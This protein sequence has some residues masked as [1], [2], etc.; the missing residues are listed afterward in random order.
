MDDPVDKPAIDYLSCATEII[1]RIQATQLGA[2]K[3]AAKL[4]AECI[5]RDGFVHMFATGHSR[6][7]VEE[8]FPRYGSIV[9]FNPLV[10][11]SL[12][13]HTEVIGSNGHAQATFLE[14]TLG[15][16]E[17]IVEGIPA[18]ET[19]VMLIFSNSGSHTVAVDVAIAARQRRIPVVLVTSV[20][21]CL[22]VHTSHPTGTKLIDIA[23]VIIDTCNPPG[24]ALVSISGMEDRV[25]PGSTIAT[26]AVANALK[27]QVAAEL[28]RL[29]TPPTVLVHKEF[30]VARSRE[31]AKMCYNL[32]R[33]LLGLLY[34]QPR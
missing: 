24:D 2:I 30:G 15:F 8:M 19:D 33:R 23:D 21:Q 11:L 17:I 9:G 29:G 22:S 6:V 16:G 13:Y 32:H 12:T 5:S 18:R 27:C 26:V 14:N 10:E 25:G 20:A 3:Q 1:Q 7:A 31:S 4:C 34:S 28:V